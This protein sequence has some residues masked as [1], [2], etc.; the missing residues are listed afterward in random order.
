MSED[1]DTGSSTT[2]RR[3]LRAETAVVNG[4]VLADCTGQRGSK[5]V[6]GETATE[7]KADSELLAEIETRTPE[8]EQYSVTTSPGGTVEF[9]TISETVFYDDGLCPEIPAA[10]RFDQQQVTATING[11]F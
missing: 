3:H 11:Q 9:D 7:T 1:V 10:D 6:T 4:R 5:S 2:R 8:D